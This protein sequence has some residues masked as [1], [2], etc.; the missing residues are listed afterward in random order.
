MQKLN[1]AQMMDA[2]GEELYMELV[3]VVDGRYADD[4]DFVLRLANLKMKRANCRLK[5]VD[6]DDALWTVA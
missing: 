1:D 3:D 2:V 4:K 5:L 6:L